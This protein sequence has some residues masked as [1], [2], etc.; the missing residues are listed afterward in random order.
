MMIVSLAGKDIWLRRSA[1]ELGMN[2]TWLSKILS[3]KLSFD[4]IKVGTAMKIAALFEFESIEALRSAIQARQVELE[5]RG[6]VS[7]DTARE[8][9]GQGSTPPSPA[10]SAS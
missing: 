7:E 4:G 5:A 3:G 6:A 2:P 9:E 1:K 10:L 8:G